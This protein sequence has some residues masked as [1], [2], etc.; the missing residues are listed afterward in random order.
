M[1]EWFR[2]TFGLADFATLDALAGGVPV[3]ADGV[4]FSSHSGAMAPEWIAGARGA[5]YAADPIEHDRAPGAGDAR[6]HRIRHAR[7][8]RTVRALGLEVEALRIAGGGARSRLWKEIRADL[9]GLPAE[10]AKSNERAGRGSSPRSHRLRNAGDVPRRPSAWRSL[11]CIEPQ[12]RNRGRYD[13]AYGRYRALFEALKPM[14][15]SE[16]VGSSGSGTRTQ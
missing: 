10:T 7:C 6:G 1:L 15:G 13:E 16:G 14:F 2:Q 12:R 5:F 8:S 4:I 9:T 3:G 11:G